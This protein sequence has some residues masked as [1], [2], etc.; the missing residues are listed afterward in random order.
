MTNM[1]PV[2]YG[3]A[4]VSKSDQDD[5]EL[6][7]HGIRQEHIFSG[8]M[9]GRVMSRPGWDELMARVQPNH[10][11]VVV[12]LDR[13]SRNFD[14]VVQ[15][16]ADFTR[17]NIGTVAIKEG[18]DTTDDNAAARYFRRMMLA[19]RAHQA[20]STCERMKVDQERARAEGRPPALTPQQVDECRRMYAENQ[21]IRRTARILKVSRGRSRWRSSSRVSQ[22]PGCDNR[23]PYTA[24]GPGGL[25]YT[26]GGA[27]DGRIVRADLPL[28]EASKFP[29]IQAFSAAGNSDLCPWTNAV[30]LD[31]ERGTTIGDE[32]P[33]NTVIANAIR[34][35]G[36][37]PVPLAS[38][39]G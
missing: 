13:F 9:T 36:N 39:A 32:T 38:A 5:R 19:N 23:C 17:R 34:R 24:A 3:Y 37:S 12:W 4:R 7:N 22:C 30:P 33:A 6:A 29:G 20:D 28:F 10:I 21:S 26:A 31:I 15:I 14:D 18:V 27:S 8:Q 16:Q 11:T 1:I 35:R 25:L 2:T